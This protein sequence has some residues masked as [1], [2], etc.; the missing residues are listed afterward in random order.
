ME[1]MCHERSDLINLAGY[2]DN[3]C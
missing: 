2:C 3:V 1:E